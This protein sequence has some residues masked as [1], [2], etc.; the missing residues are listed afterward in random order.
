MDG[1]DLRR[2][3]PTWKWETVFLMSAQEQG[4]GRSISEVLSGRMDLSR[5]LI[6]RCPCFGMAQIVLLKTE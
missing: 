4:N 3:A 6:S 2:A 5:R 1:E